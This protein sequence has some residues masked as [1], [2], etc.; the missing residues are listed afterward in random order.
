MAEYMEKASKNLE[1]SQQL[2][3]MWYDQKA[4]MVEFQP[5]QEVWVLEPVA[6]RA[7]QD[8][9]SIPYPVLEKKSQVTYLVDL[10]TSRT[11]K[12]VIHVNRLKLFHDRADVTM[13]MV[14]D[15]DQEAES[16]PLPD[17]STNPKD[18]T[19]DGVIYSG[20]LSGQQQA[21]CRQVLQQFAELFSLTPGQ[22]HLCTHDVDTGDML[23]VKN[24]VF[25]H[26]D[27][28]KQSINVKLDSCNLK[29]Q[30]GLLPYKPAEKEE[31]NNYFG[32]SPTG[33]SPTLKTCNQRSIRQGPATS[34][35]SE[36][37]PGLK[38]QETPVSS[39]PA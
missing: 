13:L 5:V 21:D 10:G 38:D 29:K 6:P 37:C 36:D 26:S 39:G 34:E 11:P 24:K 4:A 33:L 23:P 28:V 19:V 2:Q 27:Q 1:A 16:E 15:E 9:W 14:T 8:K 25:R 18:G 32:P 3:K 31:D 12:R 17:L 7:L 20:T 35:A 30:E 22:T